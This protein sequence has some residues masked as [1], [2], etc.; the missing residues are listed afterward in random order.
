VFRSTPKITQPALFILALGV[1]FLLFKPD[2]SLLEVDNLTQLS[3]KGVLLQ[4]EVADTPDEQSKGLSGRAN[5]AENEGLLFVYEQPARPS[6]WMKEMNFPIDII[7]I[8]SDKK[9]AEVTAKVSPD[10]Y[11][12][13]FRPQKEI[14]YVLEVSAGTAERYGWL[15]GDLVSF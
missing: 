6:F 7:W 13:S 2:T 9:I 1:F 5:L 14:R 15:A 4:V 3:I 10:T 8:S 12:Q 11:P